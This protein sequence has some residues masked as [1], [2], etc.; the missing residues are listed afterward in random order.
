MYKLTVLNSLEELLS[1]QITVQ[2][3][4][5][6]YKEWC[7]GLEISKTQ[8]IRIE[9]EVITHDS[10]LMVKVLA[11][12]INKDSIILSLLYLDRSLEIDKKIIVIYYFFNLIQIQTNPGQTQIQTI[13]SKQKS[14]DISFRYLQMFMHNANSN[15]LDSNSIKA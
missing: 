11:Y 6:R 1:S 8:L 2:R 15:I 9:Q 12:P 13:R 10:L 5:K 3:T 4:K 7:K 14:M